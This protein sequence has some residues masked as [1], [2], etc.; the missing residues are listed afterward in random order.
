M[1]VSVLVGLA[2]GIAALSV[3]TTAEATSR[4]GTTPSDVVFTGTVVS[5]RN[6]AKGAPTGTGAWARFAV[7]DVWRNW[8]GGEI[9]PIVE[10]R[11]AT[12][13]DG[14]YAVDGR[15][16]ASF[17]VGTRY[18]VGARFSSGEWYES[19]PNGVLVFAVCTIAV[20]SLG[21]YAWYRR[22]AF[23]QPSVG[24]PR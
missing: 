15:T 7:D 22:R 19:A 8:S 9:P 17:E 6:H 14:R 24:V 16:P 18:L 5:A 23:D 10:L 21:L 11:T 3:P 2:V 13:Y 4:E 1:R 20:A 12:D